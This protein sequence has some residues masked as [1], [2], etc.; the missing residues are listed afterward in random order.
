MVS[1][2][3]AVPG[4]EEPSLFLFSPQH[5]VRR[6]CT[7]IARSPLFH[8]TSL[9]LVCLTCVLLAVEDPHAMK[10][11]PV[12][13]C[14]EVLTLAYFS[15]EAVVEIVDTTFLLY[16]RQWGHVLDLVVICNT[17]V[18]LLVDASANAEVRTA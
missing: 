6:L 4:A 17:L 9:A 5:R 8:R 7:A 10:R 13:A 12:F 16:V 15:F 14:V 18:A 3:S 2:S 11:H 1:A